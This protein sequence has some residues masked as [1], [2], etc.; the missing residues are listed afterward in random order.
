MAVNLELPKK[1]HSVNGVRIGTACAGIKQTKRDDI[2]LFVFDVGTV[3]AG[4]YTQSHF[5]AAPV[6]IAKDHEL[7]STA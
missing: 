3:V 2:A 5:A 1:V 7:T 4:V 6:L